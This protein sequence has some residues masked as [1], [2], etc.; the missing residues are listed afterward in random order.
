MLLYITVSTFVLA[1][2]LW[3]NN[4]RKN[5]NTRYLALFM[6]VV[7][8]YGITHYFVVFS[9]NVFWTAVLYNHFTPLYFLLGPLL[10]F[11]VR[12]VLTESY[13]LTKKDIFHFIPVF[14]QTIAIA[15]YFLVSFSEKLNNAR[16]IHENKNNILLLELNQF[17]DA[18]SCFLLREGFL[19]L[20]ILA[21]AI[22]IF[23]KYPA[24]KNN[25]AIS[26]KKLQTYLRWITVLLGTSFIITLYFLSI[27]IQSIQSTP[28]ETFTKTYIF[29]LV[30]GVAFFTMTFSLIL[31]PG[32]LYGIRKKKNKSTETSYLSTIEAYTVDNQ[33]EKDSLFE[34]SQRIK[35]YLNEKKPFLAMEFSITTVAIALQIPKNQVSYCFNT[36]MGTSFYKIRNELRVAHASVL[37]QGNDS[38]KLTIEA[39]GEASGFSTRSNFYSVFKE[40]VGSTPSEYVLQ[41]KNNANSLSQPC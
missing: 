19:I 30:S 14:V 26:K 16:A 23:L 32:V 22:F 6:M 9:T 8:L 24:L 20:Y 17:F 11:Y 25:P 40:I 10:F 39:I 41:W 2:F 4:F 35:S 5:K 28:E 13:Q 7:S 31:F 27:T 33:L 21:A 36:I 18:K 12:G 1:L 38:N 37:L 34:M 29:N 3:S 15:P